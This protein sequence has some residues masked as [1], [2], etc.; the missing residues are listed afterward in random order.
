[1][2][3]HGFGKQVRI[4]CFVGIPQGLRKCGLE[5][6]GITELFRISGLDPFWVS[7]HPRLVFLCPVLLAYLRRR[8][9]HQP[10][11]PVTPLFSPFLFVHLFSVM[12]VQH[13]DSVRGKL[14]CLCLSCAVGPTAGLVSVGSPCCFSRKTFRI[15]SVSPIKWCPCFV[16]LLRIV[17]LFQ[18][19]FQPGTFLEF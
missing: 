2:P 6:Q 8:P 9:A 11:L 12:G 18:P 4:L 10:C 15:L 5:P 7:A 16:A 1:M 13:T 19:R 17:P 3:H 14:R